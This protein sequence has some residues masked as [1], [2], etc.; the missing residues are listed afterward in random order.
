MP[1]WPERFLQHTFLAICRDDLARRHFAASFGHEDEH[2]VGRHVHIFDNPD[3]K[4]FVPNKVDD[5]ECGEDGN[6]FFHLAPPFS[7][8]G[9]ESSRKGSASGPSVLERMDSMFVATLLR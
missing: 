1:A 7:A 4:T 6:Q 2:L 9:L 8:A 3:P 5:G